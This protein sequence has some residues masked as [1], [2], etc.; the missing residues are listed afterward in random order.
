[1]TETDWPARTAWWYVY[2]LGA[3]G[4][5]PSALPDGAE[6]RHRVPRLHGWLPYVGELGCDGLLLGPVFASETHGYDTVDHFLVDPRLGDEDDIVALVHAA[7]G[8]GLSVLL[9]GVFNHVGRGLPRYREAVAGGPDAEAAVGFRLH[10]PKGWSPG[11]DEP[12][13][14]VF[15][16]HEH[17]VVLDHSSEAVADHVTAVMRHWLDRGVDGWRLD[18]AY[19]VPAAFWARVLPRVREHHPD[20]WF[21]GEVIHGDYAGYVAESGLDSV[22]HYELWKAV[23]SSLNDVNPHELAHA[24][25]RHADFAGLPAADLRRQPRRHPHRQPARRPAAPGARPRRAGDGRRVAEHL[26]PR[27]ARHP[28]RQGG[29]RWRRRRDPA[30][31]ARFAPG[32]RG[33]GRRGSRHYELTRGLL[34]LRADRPWLATSRTEV[35][36]VDA[37]AIAYRSA[38]TAAR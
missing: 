14:E 6:V 35:V 34:R 38:G 28:R 15:E 20:G 13:P 5:E 11:G 3:L 12:E 22:T 30:R 25:G 29:A 36:L 21:M 2:P 10:W 27:R 16:G 18:A 17:L 33:P 32:A 8:H 19:A 24:L 1:V 26:L 23:W 9:G 7:H 31:A 37:A 4:G